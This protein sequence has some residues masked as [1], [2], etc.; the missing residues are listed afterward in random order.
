MSSEEE[1]VKVWVEIRKASCLI[2][3]VGGNTVELLL[4]SRGRSVSEVRRRIHRII[5][6]GHTAGTE[7]NY[8]HRGTLRI[9]TR[10]LKF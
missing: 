2:N 10:N 9:G 3:R 8:S 1:R 4:W 6:G 5:Y 7:R